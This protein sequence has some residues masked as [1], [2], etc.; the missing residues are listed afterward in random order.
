MVLEKVGFTNCGKR[1]CEGGEGRL[2]SW[3]GG[4]LGLRIW[5]W[6]LSKSVVKK[7]GGDCR[8]DQEY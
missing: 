3:L 1:H 7:R 5:A 2:W 6:S 4:L 8:A